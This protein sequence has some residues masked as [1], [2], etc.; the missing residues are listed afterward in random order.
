VGIGI[1]SSLIA[2]GILAVVGGLYR[3]YVNKIEITHPVPNEALTDPTCEGTI[4]TF[5]VWGKLKRLPNGHEIW[6]L[7]E[8]EHTKHIWPQGF[9]HVVYNPQEGTWQGKINGTG[10]DRVKIIAVVAPQT[11]QDFF[12]YYEAV[13]AKHNTAF[14]PLL[15]VPPECRNIDSVQARVP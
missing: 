9:F 7:V 13:G 14:E 10:R 11:S 4:T 8:D 15:R 2:G 5:P 3:R 12:R 1:I 6:L